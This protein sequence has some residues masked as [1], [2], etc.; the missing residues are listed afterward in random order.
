[1]AKDPSDKEPKNED[2]VVEDEESN[3]E[4]KG[5]RIAGLISSSDTPPGTDV[6]LFDELDEFDDNGNHIATSSGAVESGGE[7]G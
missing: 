3:T 5:P 4:E 6:A 2:P 1:M 7:D